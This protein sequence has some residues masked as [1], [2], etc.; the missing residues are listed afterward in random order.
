[1]WWILSVPTME[2]WAVY[3]ACF[4]NAFYEPR[5]GWVG[6]SGRGRLSVFWHH[7]HCHHCPRFM[8][9]VL[10]EAALDGTESINTNP[11][12]PTVS[13]DIYLDS[14]IS[15]PRSLSL[16]LSLSL[17]FH[18]SSF[19]F[20]ALSGWEWAYGVEALVLIHLLYIDRSLYSA[21]MS[22]NVEWWDDHGGIGFSAFFSRILFIRAQD[23]VG[24][25]NGDDV[26]VECLW[27]LGIC[28]WFQPWPG[29]G[30][31]VQ[32]SESLKWM[33]Q[34]RRPLG[35]TPPWRMSRVILWNVASS[36][37]GGL[38]PLPMAWR[39]P[40]WQRAAVSIR[41]GGFQG[42][43]RASRLGRR[44]SPELRGRRAARQR[45]TGSGPADVVVSCRSAAARRVIIIIQGCGQ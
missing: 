42:R 17:F 14:L 30:L 21:V 41:P 29:R 26:G 15:L 27:L 23:A 2:P 24:V 6:R 25:S 31:L 9:E 11:T 35:A 12:P 37:F 40:L 33:P 43:R 8:W 32:R 1:V 4:F 10:T 45:G 34:V 3:C 7:H 16:S 39:F 20:H 5:L 18:L 19:L 13:A 38:V 36:R 44:T 28:G 22:D